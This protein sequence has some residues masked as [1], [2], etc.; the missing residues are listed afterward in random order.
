MMGRE[1]GIRVVEHNGVEYVANVQ[2]GPCSK[3][4]AAEDKRI[5]REI[6]EYEATQRSVPPKEA[7]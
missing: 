7:K 5:M 2:Y 4:N 3:C 1:E 6:H